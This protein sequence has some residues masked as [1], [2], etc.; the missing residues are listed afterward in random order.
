MKITAED[1]LKR[2]DKLE[3]RPDYDLSPTAAAKK[4]AE[5]ALVM[6]YQLARIAD[7]IDPLVKKGKIEHL[8]LQAR[9]EAARAR[10]RTAADE[11]ENV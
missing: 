10:K 11:V 7:A 9:K 2:L 4:Y 6:A 5:A 1:V 8:T 3:A